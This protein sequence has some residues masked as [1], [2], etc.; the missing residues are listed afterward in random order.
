MKFKILHLLK[1][2]EK[3]KVLHEEIWHEKP[4]TLVLP[5]YMQGEIFNNNY[6]FKKFGALRLSSMDIIWSF[7]RDYSIKFLKLKHKC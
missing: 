1:E 5:F 2:I 6:N 3:G 7:S 4:D